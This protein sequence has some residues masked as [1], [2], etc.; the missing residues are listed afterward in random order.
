MNVETP[1]QVDVSVIGGGPTGISA[2]LELSKRRDLS[3]ALFESESEIG[4]IPRRCRLFFGMRDLK[5]IYTGPAYVKKL[6]RLILK[7]SVTIYT[8][9]TVLEIIAPKDSS[10]RIRIKVSSPHGF[11]IFE[12][13]FVLLATGCFESSQGSR[14]IPGT[15]P[16]G[17]Y[18]TG[19][20]Q[21]W[22]NLRG[23]RPGKRAVIVGSEYIA[24]SSVLTLIKAGISIGGLVEESEYLSSNELLA[25]AISKYFRF[26]IYKK[27][28]PIALKGYDR[29]EAI[30]LAAKEP[31]RSFDVACDTVILT[32]KFRPDSAII[33]S[34]TIQQDPVTLAPLVGRD[35]MTSQPR[36]FAAGNILGKA[37]MHDVCA[38]EGRRA[39]RHII[40]RIKAF[41]T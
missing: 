5:R 9:T 13:L 34:T 2:C 1:T 36:I 7:T 22:A 31:R 6:E 12:S 24:L 14:L 35:F 37:K 21:D 4:G 20:L 15:R 23:K 28:S 18:T 25:R 16:A 19:S 8:N 10:H 41:G 27:T 39:A 38:L 17:V 11:F 33:D 3:I 26:P 40:T 30:Q 32:G 29:V